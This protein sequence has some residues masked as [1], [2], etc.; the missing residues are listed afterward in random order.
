MPEAQDRA[1]ARRARV[2]DPRCGAG[3]L[4]EHRRIWEG[5]PVL[6]PIY[7]VWF[8][9]LLASLPEEGTALEVGAGPGFLAEHARGRFPKRR[10]LATD[11]MAAPWNDLVADALRLPLRDG[12]VAAVAALDLVHHLARPAA[13]FA[14]AARV[15]RRGGRLAVLEPWVT[16]LSYPV[17]RFAHQEGCDLRLDPW[18][19]FPLAGASKRPFEGDAAVLRRLLR[20]TPDEH[21]SRW[22]LGPPR[23]RALN[24][25][26]Y[27]LSLGF[28]E[29]SLL[30]QGVARPL[31]R[32]DEALA[33]W[34]AWLGVRALAVWDR[35]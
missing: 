19:P 18:D 35:V 17:Y 7:A 3:V 28:W 10:W 33:P 16:V 13:F 20:S 26:A 32:L 14:E 12:S 9:A 25:F 2:L 31:L 15:L 1:G 6:A 27:L 21:W 22:G 23:V 5:K 8:E 4:H 30:P 34:A 11:V 29:G 24:G